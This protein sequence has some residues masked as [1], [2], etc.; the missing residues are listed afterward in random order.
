MASDPNEQGS[1]P[2]YRFVRG[3]CRAVGTIGRIDRRVSCSLY[4]ESLLRRGGLHRHRYD[5]DG[6]GR[7]AGLRNQRPVDR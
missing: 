4:G 6:S 1:H 7:T 5:P 2:V 3:R